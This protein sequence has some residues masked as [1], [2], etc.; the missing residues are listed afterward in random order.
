[1]APQEYIPL[2]PHCIG[3]YLGTWLTS[4]SDIYSS[5]YGGSI[6]ECCYY[7][8][9]HLSHFPDWV[10]WQTF[11]AG[12][13]EAALNLPLPM[14]P[15]CSVLLPALLSEAK[16]TDFIETQKVTHCPVWHI[17]RLGLHMHAFQQPCWSYAPQRQEEL[18]GC[19]WIP[20]M[21]PEDTYIKEPINCLCNTRTEFALAMNI[22][23][24]CVAAYENGSDERMTPRLDCYHTGWKMHQTTSKLLM[25]HL[26]AKVALASR[27]QHSG[28]KR[29]IPWR[30]DQLSKRHMQQNIL[31]NTST[32]LLSFIYRIHVCSYL[33]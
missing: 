24:I 16:V 13:H 25:E 2:T 27:M 23:R 5:P 31:C 22:V 6:H 7:S 8:H 18:K 26:R 1:M 28:G 21:R 17:D 10:S 15:A 33:M 12:R 20:P 4:L 32:S 3:I 19:G 29:K 11:T 14:W 9:F 30:S